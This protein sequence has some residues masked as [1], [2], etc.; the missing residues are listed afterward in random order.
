MM[1]VPVPWHPPGVWGYHFYNKNTKRD[2]I[3]GKET[4]LQEIIIIGINR[5]RL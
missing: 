1:P 3:R 5:K 4:E 2:A